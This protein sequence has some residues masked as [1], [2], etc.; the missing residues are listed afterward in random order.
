MSTPTPIEAPTHYLGETPRPR[1]G[2][3][4]LGVPGAPTEWGGS[5]LA[6]FTRLVLDTYGRTCW[7]CGLPGADSVDHVIPRSRGGA[8]W[9]IDN[10]APSHVRCNISRGARDPSEAA[11]LIED[12][13]PFFRP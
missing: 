10:A 6:P 7:L 11:R 5:R 1:R 9:D 8:V 3:G 13:T 2:P 12:G 4:T